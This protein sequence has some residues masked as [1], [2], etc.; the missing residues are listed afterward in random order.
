MRTRD[1]VAGA[2]VGAAVAFMLDPSRGGRRR[3]LVRDKAARATRATRE[4]L[5]TTTRDMAHR[6]RGIVAAARGRW[7]R[8]PVSDGVLI[9]R[10]R[11]KL[12]RVTSHPGAI[13]VEARDGEVTLRG[14][15][16]AHEVDDVISTV[17]RVSGVATVINEVEPHDAAEGVPSLQGEGRVQRDRI[18]VLQRRWSP[19][20]Q[21]LVAAG[22]VATGVLL[23]TRARRAS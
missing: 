5:D 19:S 16:L 1:V 9:E 20:T 22:L 3:A 15:I 21:A 10:V 12:G 13:H 4:G 18:D 2:G 14:P 23:A 7:S 17:S 6:T 11:A 8:Q